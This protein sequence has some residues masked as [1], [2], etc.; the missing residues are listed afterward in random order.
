MYLNN[1]LYNLF[2]YKV[3]RCIETIYR[4]VLRCH[5]DAFFLISSPN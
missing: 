1:N 4:K 3:E 5:R 2:I